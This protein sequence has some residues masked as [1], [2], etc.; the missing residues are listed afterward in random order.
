MKS[1]DQE[2]LNDLILAAKSNLRQRQHINIHQSYQEPCQRLFNAIEPASYIRPH[3]HI[4]DNKEELLVAVRGSLAVLNFD[5]N[6]TMVSTVLIGTEKYEGNY[7]IGVEVPPCTWHTV[8]AL[9]KG[10]VLLEVKAGPF[11]PDMPKD[12]APWAPAEGS[13]EAIIYLHNL[14]ST[15]E[16]MLKS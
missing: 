14:V 13:E 3:R 2:Y 5:D 7:S 16:V 11:N 8:V 12:F 10:S 1:F 9:E 4:S 15:L 6:G